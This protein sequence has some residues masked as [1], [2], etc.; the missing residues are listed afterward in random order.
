MLDLEG[1]QQI[2]RELQEKY[3]SKWEP[4]DPERGLNKLMW[5]VGEIGEVAQILKRKGHW[6][7]MNTP[8]VRHDFIE[9]MCDV[10]MYLN[11]VFMCYNITP[12]EVEEVYREKHAHN[13][14]RW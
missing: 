8:E 11:D 14:T 13:M 6:N 2:Q 10:F 3:K 9:E 12:E 1:M 4:I 5:T 7:V